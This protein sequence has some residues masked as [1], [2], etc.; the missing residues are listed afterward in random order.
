MASTSSERAEE[1]LKT[2]KLRSPILEVD[3][4]QAA[5]VPPE[6]PFLLPNSK[7]GPSAHHHPPGKIPEAKVW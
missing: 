6:L 1:L 7:W 3:Q 5:R 2:G 4:P